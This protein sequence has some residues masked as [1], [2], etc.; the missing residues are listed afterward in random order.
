[1]EAGL[2]ALL[3]LF[4]QY[5]ASIGEGAR[6]TSRTSGDRDLPLVLRQ[7][8][9]WSVDLSARAPLPVAVIGVGSL[10]FHHARLLNDIETSEVVGIHDADSERGQKVAAELGLRHFED[11]DE[12]L[13]LIEAAVVAV[14]TTVHA[15][16]ALPALER[17]VH[18]LIEKPIAPTL[19]DAD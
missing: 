3:R 14:P 7:V 15:E 1:V 8:R 9:A 18:L 19:E 5:L 6:R 2:S 12:L 16:V 4:V 11:L 10:G 13:G 17:G